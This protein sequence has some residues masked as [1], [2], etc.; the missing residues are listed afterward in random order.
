MI[1]SATWLKTLCW[2]SGATAT[3]LDTILK[4]YDLMPDVPRPTFV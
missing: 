4:A 3:P 2:H 1:V